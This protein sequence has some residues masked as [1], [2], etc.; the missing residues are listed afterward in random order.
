[1]PDS[2]TAAEIQFK[3]TPPPLPKPP[4]DLFLNK[5]NF[6]TNRVIQ[7]QVITWYDCLQGKKLRPISLPLKCL[8]ERKDM[9]GGGSI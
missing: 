2:F 8:N 1:M 9:G 6:E 3:V 4:S 5:Y 7:S